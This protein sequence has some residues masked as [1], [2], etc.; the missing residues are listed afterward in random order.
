[1][2][3]AVLVSCWSFRSIPLHQC[4]WPMVD[5]QILEL[6]KS[7]LKCRGILLHPQSGRRPPGALTA[8]PRQ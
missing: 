2:A 6:N 5:A 4:A 8:R 1:M 3:L 7:F